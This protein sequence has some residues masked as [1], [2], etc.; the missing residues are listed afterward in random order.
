MEYTCTI[1]KYYII[2][3]IP[4]CNLLTNDKNIRKFEIFWILMLLIEFRRK[5]KKKNDSEEKNIIMIFFF[6]AI[7]SIRVANYRIETPLT[8][9]Y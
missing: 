8:I 7:I 6:Y 4:R 3:I 1:G 2:I 9:K 5:K